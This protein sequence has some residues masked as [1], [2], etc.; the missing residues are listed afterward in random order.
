MRHADGTTG[1][2]YV[3]E[4]EKYQAELAKSEAQIQ[5]A[6]R[7]WGEEQGAAVKQRSKNP[8]KAGGAPP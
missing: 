3:P 2:A 1:Q 6:N 4:F 7:Q 8:P 5:K